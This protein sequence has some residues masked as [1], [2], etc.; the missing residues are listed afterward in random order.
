MKHER[1][2]PHPAFVER[3]WRW[4]G[5]L[6]PAAFGALSIGR[7]QPVVATPLIEEALWETQRGGD[8][9]SLLLQMQAG[10]AKRI[11]DPLQSNPSA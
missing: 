1:R 8:L 10:P 2:P 3:N 6:H 5:S 9:V 11:Q 4:C 7:I